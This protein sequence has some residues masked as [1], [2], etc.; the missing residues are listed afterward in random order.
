MCCLLFVFCLLCVVRRS[1]FSVFFLFRL[2][3][4]RCVL[5]VVCCT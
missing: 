5:F 2:V 1:L 3:G 4:V